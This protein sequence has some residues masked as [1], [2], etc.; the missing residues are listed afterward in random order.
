MMK[1]EKVVTVCSA[2]LNRSVGLARVL[3]NNCGVSAIAV[4]IDHDDGNLEPLFEW[5]DRIILLHEDWVTQGRVPERFRD[6]V[7]LWHVGL[8]IWGS[9]TNEELLTLF[10][11]KIL[12]TGLF[13]Y[14]F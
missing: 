7:I 13:E 11:N 4:G 2:G 9:P 3:R 8:D 14:H 10:K 6:K 5:A 12:E 1:R